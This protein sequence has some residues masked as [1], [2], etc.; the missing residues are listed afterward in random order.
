MEKLNLNLV[1]NRVMERIEE[2]RNEGEYNDE[3]LIELV[4]EYKELMK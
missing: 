1:E 2:M 3:K 4:N